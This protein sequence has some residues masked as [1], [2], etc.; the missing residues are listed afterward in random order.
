MG[1]G[2]SCSSTA[3][4]N[5][6]CAKLRTRPMTATTNENGFTK[7]SSKKSATWSEILQSNGDGTT[8][9]TQPRIQNSMLSSKSTPDYL[10][11][12]SQAG[13]PRHRS[14]GVAR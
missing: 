8:P 9:K 13:M 1:S 7:K 3:S 11:L 6:S 10:W 2:A 14:S 12:L 4:S 5:A